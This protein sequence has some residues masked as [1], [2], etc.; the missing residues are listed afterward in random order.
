M[1]LLLQNS[2]FAAYVTFYH[3]IKVDCAVLRRLCTC[4]EPKKVQIAGL[5]LFSKLKVPRT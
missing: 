2:F 4:C 1:V 3:N 5:P